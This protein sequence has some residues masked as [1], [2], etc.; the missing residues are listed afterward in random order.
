MCASLNLE[1]YKQVVEN[2]PEAILI[3]VEMKIVYS[4]KKAFM[5]CGADSPREIIRQDALDFILPQ[6]PR[7]SRAREFEEKRLHC[8]H[9]EELLEVPARLKDGRDI[10]LEIN[11]CDITFQ[12]MVGSLWVVRDITTK[13]HM[14]NRIQSLHVSAALLGWTTNVDEAAEIVLDALKR[15]RGGAIRFHWM[16]PGS[17]LEPS[18]P[19]RPKW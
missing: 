9:C 4:N 12:D 19:I 2:C 3:L 18:T 8:E 17:L 5:I 7:E 14:E 10:P 11:I 6:T 13:K 16:D 15:A 1:T